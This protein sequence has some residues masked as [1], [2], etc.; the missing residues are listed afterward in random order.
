MNL[1]DNFIRVGRAIDSL[2]EEAFHVEDVESKATFDQ[3]SLRFG[4]T[5]G[6]TNHAHFEVEPVRSHG[7]LELSAFFEVKFDELVNHIAQQEVV[8]SFVS[9]QQVRLIKVDLGDW[10]GLLRGSFTASSSRFSWGVKH[11]H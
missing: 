2:L 1:G 5:E 8:F 9:K 4:S 11:F 6:V 3:L 10:G 7:V